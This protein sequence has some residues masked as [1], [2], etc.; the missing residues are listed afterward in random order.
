MLAL[1]RSTPHIGFDWDYI[2]YNY[3]R[4]KFPDDESAKKL[5]EEILR[6][7]FKNQRDLKVQ[8]IRVS[9]YSFEI[10]VEVDWNINWH[11]YGIDVKVYHG[12]NVMLIDTGAVT[13]WL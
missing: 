1:L 13:N 4:N 9:D 12:M 7:L 6:A 2:V 8:E 5:L 3:S 11:S 10:R